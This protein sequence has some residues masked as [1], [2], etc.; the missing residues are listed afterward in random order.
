MKT[1][2]NHLLEMDLSLH[3][4]IEQSVDFG[5]YGMHDFLVGASTYF[6]SNWL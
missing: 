1:P 6:L 4:C 3:C 2:V 5:E